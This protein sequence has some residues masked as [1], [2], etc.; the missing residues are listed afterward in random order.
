MRGREAS[1][2]AAAGLGAGAACIAGLAF[3]EAVGL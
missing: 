1:S 3:G 2:Q